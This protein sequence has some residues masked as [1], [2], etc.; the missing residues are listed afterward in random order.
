MRSQSAME[1]L[2][3]YGWAILV[4][5]VILGVLFQL[6]VFGSANLA[7]KAKAGQCQVQ[8]VGG[9]SSST[10][11]LAGLCSSELP[12]FVAQFNGGNSNIY[13]DSNAVLAGGSAITISLWFNAQSIPS[14]GQNGWVDEESLYGLKFSE[15]NNPTFCYTI[16]NGGAWTG[17]VSTTYSFAPNTWYNLAFTWASGGDMY[18]Y[19]N[20]VASAPSGPV[21]GTL[22]TSSVVNYF[23]IG[24]SISGT[25]TSSSALDGDMANVQLYN[26]SLSQAEITALYQEGIGGAPVRPQNIV[27]WWPL[28]GNTNDYSGN[29]NNGQGADVGY[30][31]SW[32][33][34]YT[35]P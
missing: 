13:L 11:Q 9:G 8:V 7:P 12:Q 25:P 3:T 14:S 15:P 4:I 20:G 35:Q 6:G 28:N 34:G 18:F 16:N 27:G 26:A 17:C 5:A 22:G 2:M 24:P 1:Y 21:T 31:S 19:I 32:T 30:S 23:E 33:N 10:H 29:N